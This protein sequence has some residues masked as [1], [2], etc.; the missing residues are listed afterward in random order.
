MHIVKVLSP[1][2][3][4]NSSISHPVRSDVRK[5]RLPLD[6]Y[7]LTGIENLLGPG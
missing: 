3:D 6:L 1:S 4:R 2:N 5:R 7:L